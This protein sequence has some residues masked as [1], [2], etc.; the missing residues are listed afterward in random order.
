MVAQFNEMKN[1]DVEVVLQCVKDTSCLTLHQSLE[2]GWVI[3]T[4]PN[5]DV[6]EGRKVTFKLHQE[7]KLSRPAVKHII[8][9]FDNVSAA[10]GY[11][12]SA[13]ADLSLLS[14]LVDPET[15]KMILCA[16]VCPLVQLSIPDRFLDPN[17]DPDVDTLTE[18]IHKR[19]AHDLLPKANHTALAR[20][21]N[22]GP[23]RLLCAALWL[24]LNHMFF[25]QGTQKE[26][27]SMFTVWEKQLSRLLMGC[28]YMGGTDKR[29]PSDK[30]TD[31]KQSRLC[32]RKSQPAG[33]A[34]KPPE[35]DDPRA[36]GDTIE[37]KEAQ[38]AIMT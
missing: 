14:K 38:S 13:T 33:T 6:P 24:K 22:N 11:L 7:K 30:G 15:F 16:G 29:K 12:S 1:A 17:R 18:S 8:T 37:P 32:H 23:T 5:K 26:A 20:E 2:E 10:N 27:C 31:E 19:I 28:K 25:N 3:K 21:P 4:D 35:E 9:Y 34:V 36:E